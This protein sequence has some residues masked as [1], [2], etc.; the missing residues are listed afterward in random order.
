MSKEENPL[1]KLTFV[2]NQK[3]SIIGLMKKMV[4]ISLMRKKVDKKK[5][6]WFALNVQRLWRFREERNLK[7]QSFLQMI[8]DFEDLM[9]ST[10]M[11]GNEAEFSSTLNT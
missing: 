5:I 6:L 10:K 3:E 4:V 9:E 2:W 11:K 8:E 1:K 7:L